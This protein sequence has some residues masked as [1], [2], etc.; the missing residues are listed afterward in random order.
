M[1]RQPTAL[2][3]LNNR[4][5]LPEGGSILSQLSSTLSGGWEFIFQRFAQAVGALP[6]VRHIALDIGAIE[7]Y[8]KDHGKGKS[9][10]DKWALVWFRRETFFG[11]GVKV[12][13]LPNNLV[14]SDE[15][16]SLTK[17]RAM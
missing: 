10:V 13:K 5:V 3:Y 9:N 12:F 4:K 6:P 8:R 11:G 1:G 7:V 15:G 2:V 16:G 17:K 14:L